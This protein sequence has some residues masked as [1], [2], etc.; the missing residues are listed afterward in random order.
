MEPKLI[1]FAEFLASGVIE[2][3]KQV[4]RVDSRKVEDLYLPYGIFAFRFFDMVIAQVNMDGEM[5][6]LRSEP[7][8]WSPLHYF[9]G[10]VLTLEGMKDEMPELVGVIL[11]FEKERRVILTSAGQWRPFHEDDIY[12]VSL[13]A[14]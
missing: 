12:V 7:I 3:E 13:K 8:H 10:T 6:E 5:I 9:G 1:H 14:L 4:L 2:D 11:R